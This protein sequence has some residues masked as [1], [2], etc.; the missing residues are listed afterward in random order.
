MKCFQL[1]D[2]DRINNIAW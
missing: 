1:F 2:S